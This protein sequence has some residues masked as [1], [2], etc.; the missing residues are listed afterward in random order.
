MKNLLNPLL[1]QQRTL[2]YPGCPVTIPDPS[3]SDCPTKE[4][5][6]IRSLFLVKEGFAFTDITNVAEWTTGINNKDIYVFPYTRGSLEQNETESTGFGD[7][8]TNLDGYEY[9]LTVMEPNYKDN[10]AFW[11]EIKRARNFRP[12]WRTENLV[13][14]ADN[15]AQFIPKQPVAEDKKA[16]VLWMIIA[17]FSQEDLVQPFDMPTGVFEECIAVQ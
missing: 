9:V 13:H 10:Y 3:C 11:N 5:G 2:Y 1:M 16:Q 8:E 12:G 15:S 17:K 6:D 4:L 14:L 7:Q